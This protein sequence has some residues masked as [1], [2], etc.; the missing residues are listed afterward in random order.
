MQRQAQEGQFYPMSPL[1]P[2]PNTAIMAAAV[3]HM[4]VVTI[5]SHEVLRLCMR[6]SAIYLA[7]APP[8]SLN[9]PSADPTVTRLPSH[10][11]E[12]SMDLVSQ[13]SLLKSMILL[14]V[15]PPQQTLMAAEPH[16]VAVSSKA[17]APAELQALAELPE[18]LMQCQYVPGP[19]LVNVLCSAILKCGMPIQAKVR[20]L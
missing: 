3:V 13:V 17:C 18:I 12:H 5:T 10:N 16:W 2:S 15:L 8:G 19:A 9:L 4:N 6:I 11:L 14:K 1:L 7:E 20:Q